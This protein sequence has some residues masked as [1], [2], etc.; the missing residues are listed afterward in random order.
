MTT[1]LLV[2]YYAITT[3]LYIVG[4]IAYYSSIMIFIVTMMF[5]DLQPITVLLFGLGLGIT[6][7]LFAKFK[8]LYY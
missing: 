5:F 3:I 6:Q 8:H 7:L 2:L 1:A 4:R